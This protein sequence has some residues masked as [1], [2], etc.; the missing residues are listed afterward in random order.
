MKP[1][2][3]L[4]F[5]PGALLIAT[6]L[7]AAP[8]P[9][10]PLA[11]FA[12][13]PASITVPGTKAVVEVPLEL[14][15]ARAASGL[16]EEL[17]FSLTKAQKEA[18]RRDKFVLIPI[19]TLPTI[20]PM[21]REPYVPETPEEAKYYPKPLGGLGVYE[22]EMLAIYQRIGGGGEL[23]PW[24]NHFVTADSML[25]A[26]HR[27]FEGAL[28]E[29]ESKELYPRL[30]AFLT[31]WLSSLRLLRENASPSLAPHYEQIE[32]QIAVALVLLGDDGEEPRKEISSGWDDQGNPKVISM[33]SLADRAETVL[34][35]LP[36]KWQVAARNEVKL[37]LGKAGLSPSPLFVSYD[38]EKGQDYTQFTPR[39]HYAKN[40]ALRAYFRSMMYLGR[41]GWPLVAPAG[42]DG[43]SG[44]SHAL[45]LGHSLTL[46]APDGKVPL[47]DWRALM[48]ITSFFAGGSD[49]VD[50][51][52]LRR[53]L[54][55]HADLAAWTPERAVDAALLAE[56]GEKLGELRQ[57]GI[58]SQV[59]Q[60]RKPGESG[61][62]V[63]SDSLQ[64]RVFGQRFT[65]DA[66]VLTELT[67]PMMNSLPATPTALYVAAALGDP[68][69]RELALSWL[70]QRDIKDAAPFEARLDELAATLAGVSEA[71]WFS[72]MASKKLHLIGTLAGKKGDGFPAF[73]RSPQWGAKHVETMLG[74]YTQL[75][76]DTLL[77]AKQS[78]AEMGE[79]GDT[80][81]INEDDVPYGFV[82]P[83]VRFWAE[84]DR[85]VNYT[86]EGF[87]KHKLL[88]NVV[89]EWG[90]LGRFKKDVASL[91][92]LANKTAAGEKWNLEDRLW[93]LE[94]NPVYMA[95]PLDPMNVQ[96]PDDGKAA[97]VADIQ[98][99]VQ[100]SKVLYQALGR[101]YLILALVG[102]G[103]MNRL[104]VG[105][106]Y[107]Y[108]EF[109]E[110]LQERLTDEA[111][112]KRFYAIDPDPQPK[113]D[114]T[115]P[116][117]K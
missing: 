17:G 79:G 10:A 94:F 7:T 3:S 59:R 19:G 51:P 84:F 29:I 56:L 65:Y 96:G 117:V 103:G 8:W 4:R 62:E 87:T 23:Q 104:V 108:Y 110:P 55:G 2:F 115:V 40:Q 99:N 30:D 67:P 83:E 64:F 76:H 42:Q 48:E 97:I 90:H 13:V 102:D 28:E 22:D 89:E 1:Q 25:H 6:S 24:R 18:L 60:R 68:T 107:D 44:L 50:Y 33:P 26:W 116:A 101:P 92:G 53:W 95:E 93:L 74:A 112:R 35:A 11:T 52:E 49:D 63:R 21:D 77:Y 43:A 58:L 114:W 88:P 98:T 80:D 81:K 9:E 100:E 78:Y 14:D 36:Q 45:L 47:D 41:N 75:K 57:P 66:W 113:P 85:L 61:D 111:W 72:S 54:A 15:S 106:A 109:V 5:L 27:F 20:D 31:S 91:R 86:F 16:F 46:P 34:G 82:Q 32:A 38:P 73:M 37:I 71:E 39:S 12:D 69:A 70:R 105:T